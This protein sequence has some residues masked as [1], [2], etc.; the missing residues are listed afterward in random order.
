ML[1][2]IPVIYCK[3]VA[4]GFD[5]LILQQ[6]AVYT[7]V[8]VNLLPRNLIE[9]YCNLPVTFCSVHAIKLRINGNQS[10]QSKQCPLFTSLLRT[11]V[12]HLVTN[13]TLRHSC[14]RQLKSYIIIVINHVEAT[15]PAL[16][17]SDLKDS[18]AYCEAIMLD[19]DYIAD[20]GVIRTVFQLV[21]G[22]R[23]A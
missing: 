12:L 9:S 6:H 19:I 16:P 1:C 14:A 23:F 4:N 7:A 21:I 3:L 5:K 15:R 20:D 8:P 2:S 17:L 10:G 22:L 11:E 18:H 13:L